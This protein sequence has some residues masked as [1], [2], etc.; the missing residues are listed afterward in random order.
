[1]S[2]GRVVYVCGFGRSGST[3]LGRLLSEREQAVSVGEATHVGSERFLARATCACGQPYAGCPFWSRVDSALA[4]RAGATGAMARTRRLEGLL[5]LLLPLA[6]L[7][8]LVLRVPFSSRYPGV[9]Y[10][11]GVRALLDAAGGAVVDGSKTTRLTANRPRLLAAAGADV[12]LVLAR[13]PVSGIVESHVAAAKRRGSSRSRSRSLVSV[14]AGRPL[15][16]A[17]ARLCALSLRTPLPVVRL[18]DSLRELASRTEPDVWPRDHAIA[19]NRRRHQAS[20]A[21]GVG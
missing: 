2:A 4:G 16:D 18:A 3:L 21:G 6:V 15:A 13:R 11:E 17:C 8:R 1:M 10:A 9:T 12:T 14:L 20:S 7:R 5:G 19:G